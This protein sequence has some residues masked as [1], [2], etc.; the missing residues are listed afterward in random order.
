MQEILLKIRHFERGLSKSFK[1]GNYF[2]F[3]TQ[4]LSMDKIIKN[5]RGLELVTSCSSGY[6]TSLEKFLC[7]VLSDQ[8]WWCSIKPFLSYSKNYTTANLWKWIHDVINYSTSICPFESGKYGK[9]EK[10]YK[11]LNI[12]K[13]KSFLDEIKSSFIVFEGLSFGEKRKIW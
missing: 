1:K 3:W 9:E 6:K 10:N 4:S 7:Y 2:F 13:T 11:N 5:K 8:V 12:S